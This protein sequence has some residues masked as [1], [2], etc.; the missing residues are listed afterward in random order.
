[1]S[2]LL[3]STIVAVKEGVVVESLDSIGLLR[4]RAGK[5]YVI[6]GWN[7][8]VVIDETRVVITKYRRRE[9]IKYD[10]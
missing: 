10:Q 9:A 5:Y 2:L 7:S 8:R 1:M 4:P 3:W 6:V